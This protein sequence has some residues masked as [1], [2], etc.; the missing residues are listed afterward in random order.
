MVLCM[1]FTQASPTLHRLTPLAQRFLWVEYQKRNSY[2]LCLILR[3]FTIALSSFP[4]LPIY[5]RR[6]FNWTLLVRLS[7][8]IVAGGSLTIYTVI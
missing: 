8:S 3:M 4:G 2:L 1:R 5:L 6:Q 7:E